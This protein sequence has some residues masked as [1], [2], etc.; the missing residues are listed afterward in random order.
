MTAVGTEGSEID[1][2]RATA[3]QRDRREG[4]IKPEVSR[5][6]AQPEAKP[7]IGRRVDQTA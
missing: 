7:K 2:S 6:A 1:W 5:S 4:E 3:A